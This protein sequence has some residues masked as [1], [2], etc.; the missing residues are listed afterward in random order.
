MHL[1]EDGVPYASLLLDIELVS[2]DSIQRSQPLDESFDN[3]RTNILNS[4][5]NNKQKL[6][7]Q[8]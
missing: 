2:S 4:C 7:L 6:E 8:E 3:V 1:V 5:S